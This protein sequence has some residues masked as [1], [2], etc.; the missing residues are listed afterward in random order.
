MLAEDADSMAEMP[1][2]PL[3]GSGRNPRGSKEGASKVSTGESNDPPETNLLMEA[4]VE[5]ENMKEA[6]RR[7]VANG[8]A[9]GIDGM[10]VEALKPYLRGQ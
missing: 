2:S 3:G 9:A 7:V 10:T 8:G 1:E 5:R 6:L 4:V